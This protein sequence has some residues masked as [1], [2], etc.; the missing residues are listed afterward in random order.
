VETREPAQ[1]QASK[2]RKQ[3]R[4]LAPLAWIRTS[5]RAHIH[6]S[7]LKRLLYFPA[8]HSL[9]LGKHLGSA[10]ADHLTV[11]GREGCVMSGPT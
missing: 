1:Q 11:L 4:L 2:D 5:L 9:A 3:A 6:R 10:K 8:K 7:Q